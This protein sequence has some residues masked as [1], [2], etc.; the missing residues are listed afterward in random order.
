MEIAL[1]YA[2]TAASNHRDTRAIP[3]PHLG[4]GG[5]RLLQRAHRQHFRLLARFSFDPLR[6]YSL[7]PTGRRYF[8]RGANRLHHRRHVRRHRLLHHRRHYPQRCFNR[9]FRAFFFNLRGHRSGHRC[10]RW[11]QR[12]FRGLCR[13]QIPNPC[14]HLSHHHRHDRHTQR[15]HEYTPAGSNPPDPDRELTRGMARFK[16]CHMTWI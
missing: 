1:S 3:L 15:L 13:L 12:Q 8:H 5:P 9:V 10:R 4:V 16:A 6:C 7:D 11:L 2:T 14:R